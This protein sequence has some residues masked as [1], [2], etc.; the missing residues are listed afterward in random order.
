MLGLSTKEG[1]PF[2]CTPVYLLLSSCNLFFLACNYKYKY[3]CPRKDRPCTVQ[4][5]SANSLFRNLHS[6]CHMSQSFFEF[7]EYYF[8]FWFFV[9]SE[10]RLCHNQYESVSYLQLDYLPNSFES[11]ISLLNDLPSISVLFPVNKRKV[12]SRVDIF[13]M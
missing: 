4:D 11:F 7:R 8:F 10:Q 13:C 5:F 3:L 9:L 1:P 12:S 2:L 6:R